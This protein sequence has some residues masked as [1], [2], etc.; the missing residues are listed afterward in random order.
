METIRANVQHLVE[1]VAPQTAAQPTTPPS[2]GILP[3]T[4]VEPRL[5][6]PERYEG[7]PGS[8]RSFLSTCSLVFELQPS[9]FLTKCSRVAYVITLLSGRAHEWG[10]AVWEAN[11]PACQTFSKLAQAMR[12]CSTN[13]CLTCRHASAVSYPPRSTF[14]VGLCH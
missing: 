2:P 6:A 13:L 4:S 11:A 5:L 7:D 8:F 1:S 9:S 10:T 14:S 3:Q 12:G